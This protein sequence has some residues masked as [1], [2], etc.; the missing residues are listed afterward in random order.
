MAA[1]PAIH[2]MLVIAGSMA[3]KGAEI[4]EVMEGF[5][6]RSPKPVCVSWPS[7]PLGIPERLAARAIYSFLDPVRSAQAARGSPRTASRSRALPGPPGR[8]PTA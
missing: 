5:A 4:A 7:P 1:E 2:S 6:S 8:R 3:A